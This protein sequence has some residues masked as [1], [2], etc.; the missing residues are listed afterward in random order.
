[1]NTRK[2]FFINNDQKPS[3]GFTFA[4]EQHQAALKQFGEND[5]RTVDALLLLMLEA[6]LEL[7]SEIEQAAHAQRH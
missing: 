2:E 5:Q 3:D 4:I 7:F 1:M 6:P